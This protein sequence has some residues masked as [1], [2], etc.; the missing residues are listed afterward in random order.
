MTATAFKLVE[1]VQARRVKGNSQKR[2]AQ[3]LRL[4]EKHDSYCVYCSKEVHRGDGENHGPDVAT[5]DHIIPRHMGGPD[6]EAN[7]TLACYRCNQELS[8]LNL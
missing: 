8:R 2:R 4:M 6:I 1:N 5:R 7:Y 3:I